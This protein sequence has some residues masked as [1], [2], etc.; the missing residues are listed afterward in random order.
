[1]DTIMTPERIYELEVEDGVLTSDEILLGYHFC[2]DFDFLVV[3]PEDPEHQICTCPKI[4][5]QP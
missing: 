2:P 4:E 1:M 3:G 5:D